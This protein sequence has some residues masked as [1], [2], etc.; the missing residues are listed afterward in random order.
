MK[1]ENYDVSLNIEREKNWKIQM[2]GMT[3]IKTI[4]ILKDYKNI[5]VMV[6]LKIGLGY[7]TS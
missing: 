4:E 5:Y 1:K 7:K 3:D 6:G 2:W